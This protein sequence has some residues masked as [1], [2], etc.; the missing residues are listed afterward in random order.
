MS[1]G[2]VRPLRQIEENFV[3]HK[4]AKENVS[5]VRQSSRSDKGDIYRK[6]IVSY[7]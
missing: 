1:I 4:I 2:T 5:D 3:L 6:G 7:G